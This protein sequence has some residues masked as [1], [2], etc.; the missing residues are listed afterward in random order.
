[1]D[2]HTTLDDT[3]T[4]AQT[5]RNDIL[6]AAAVDMC[7]DGIATTATEEEVVQ[8]TN[9]WSKRRRAMVA[10]ATALVVVGG[11]VAA[12]VLVQAPNSTTVATVGT[13]GDVSVCYDSYNDVNIAAHFKTIR[14]RFT[15]VRTYQTRGFRNAI[16]VAAEAGL[17]IYAGVWIRTDEGSINADMQAVVDGVRRNPSVVKGVFVG[18]EELH[19]GIDQ[20]TVL[21]RVRQM[22]Q[23][24]QAAGL[25]WVPVGSVQVDGNW[26]GAGA[27]ANECD[28]IGV[29]IHPFFSAASV[30]T[31]NP[32]EDLKV[33]WNAMYNAYGGRAVLTETGWPTSGSQF[34]GHWPSF[35]TAK[36]YY[37]QVL[38]WAKANGG[39]MPS[40][41]M[42]HD[43]ALKPTD[44]E[45]A[46]GLAWSNGVWKWDA[47]A[48]TEVKGVVFVNTAN[49]QVLAAVP[50]SRT[51]E[52]HAKWGSDW[53]WDWSS[54]WTIRGALIVT[55]DAANKVDLCLDAY[56]GWNGG[57][58]HLWPCDAANGNQQWNYDGNAKLL[59]H[60]KFTGFCLDMGNANGGIPHLWA[61]HDSWDPW[62]KLQQLEWWTK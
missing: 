36:N 50:S 5:P 12:L 25:G 31:W 45:K 53:V 4:M 14:Q 16:D 44:F 15:G 7:E 49:N 39:N 9:K 29:N 18:N 26:A 28:L 22:R 21:A 56:E 1:M 20:W 42:F 34:Y 30:S 59:R 47:P 51:V 61:C 33:R 10:L 40:H 37:F 19:E 11:I 62:V 48:A 46:F 17:K 32:I 3:C 55:W 24:L 35:D 8:T 23:R 6:Y 27:L 38:E 58:V 41:F 13:G 54:Q 2:V 43:N 52:F 60:A 57:T